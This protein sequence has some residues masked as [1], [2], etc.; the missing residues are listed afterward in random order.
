MEQ[1]ERKAGEAYSLG[2]IGDGV[3]EVVVAMGARG[4]GA[5]SSG[6]GAGAGVDAPRH[7]AAGV[8][9]LVDGHGERLTVQELLLGRR[10]LG[11]KGQWRPI[12]LLRDTAAAP[13]CSLRGMHANAL[14]IRD[15][16]LWRKKGGRLENRSAETSKKTK[17]RFLLQEGWE[18]G[19]HRKRKNSTG[20]RNSYW[21][22]LNLK[23]NGG[24][25]ERF[26]SKWEEEQER[27]APCPAL[28]G[29]KHGWLVG[30]AKAMRGG[31]GSTEQI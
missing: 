15:D 1:N 2:G 14:P 12:R 25:E 26:F 13:R 3:R 9:V 28:S 6:H 19:S 27:T 30:L 10:E 4:A 18:F 24:R 29:E 22:K 20:T 23:K 16:S 8:E 7:G 17:G 21:K 5:D 31:R 11:A